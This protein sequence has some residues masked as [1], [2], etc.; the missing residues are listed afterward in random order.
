M[1][2]RLGNNP[3]LNSDYGIAGAA[4]EIV[5]PR[6]YCP[7]CGSLN[8]DLKQL[9]DSEPIWECWDCAGEFRLTFPV[10]RRF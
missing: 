5:Y 4:P 7:H 3:G 10:R 1:R 2:I 8:I 9:S 6:M